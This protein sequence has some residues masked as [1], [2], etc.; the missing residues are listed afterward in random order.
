MGEPRGEAGAVKLT[1]EDPQGPRPEEILALQYEFGN[2][3]EWEEAYNLFAQESKERVSLEQYRSYFEKGPPFAT[4]DYA[5][6]SVS[7][8]GDHAT[9][10]RV[11]TQQDDQG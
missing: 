4:V 3:S 2:M 8:E 10:E 11:F 5:F 9:I 6:P 7:I 1:R